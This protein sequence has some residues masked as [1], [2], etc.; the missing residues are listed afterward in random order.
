MTISD[1]LRDLTR[2]LSEAREHHGGARSEPPAISEKTVY[3]TPG[4][5]AF[6]TKEEAEASA[7]RCRLGVAMKLFSDPDRFLYPPEY[8]CRRE[9]PEDSFHDFAR[10]MVEADP[11][12]ARMLTDLLNAFVEKQ[13][14]RHKAKGL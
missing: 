3:V 5:G 12:V 8:Q 4:G 14:E 1:R 9:P 7:L 10:E 6:N 2:K 13:V 11:E